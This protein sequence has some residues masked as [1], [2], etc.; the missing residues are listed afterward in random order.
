MPFGAST[1]LRRPGE[2]EFKAFKFDLLR[3][4]EGQIVEVTR[5]ENTLFP[6]FGLPLVLETA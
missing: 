1:G 4:E 2:S 6:E 5:F 3:I